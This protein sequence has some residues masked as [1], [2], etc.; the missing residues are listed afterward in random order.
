MT[1]E[2]IIACVNSLHNQQNKSEFQ[3][4][5]KQNYT[6]HTYNRNEYFRLAQARDKWDIIITIIRTNK[7]FYVKVFYYR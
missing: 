5:L 2:V 3:S 6:G 7:M 1:L 4:S